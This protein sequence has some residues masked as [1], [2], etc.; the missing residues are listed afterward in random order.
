LLRSL[1]IGM[2]GVDRWITRLR[3]V[4]ELVHIIVEVVALN[5]DVHF[6]LG[7]LNLN[8]FRWRCNFVGSPPAATAQVEARIVLMAR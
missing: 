1:L 7:N 2:W 4:H 5:E 6:V 8:V 3:A